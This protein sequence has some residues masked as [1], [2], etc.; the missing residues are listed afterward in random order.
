MR[1]VEH[2]T[3]YYVYVWIERAERGRS[4]RSQVACYWLPRLSGAEDLPR[5]LRALADV[6]ALPLAARP[7]PPAQ[8]GRRPLR[9]HGVTNP[10]R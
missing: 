10:Q 4:N 7:M 5:L 8:P 6:L 1:W 3:G 9:G 2:D